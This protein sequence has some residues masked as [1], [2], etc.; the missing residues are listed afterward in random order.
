[1]SSRYALT[2]YDPPADLARHS[3]ALFHFASDA[4]EI[5]DRHPGALPQ[6]T[7]FPYGSGEMHFD[8]GTQVVSGEAHMLSGFS[9]AVPYTMTGPWHAIGI[10]L[11]H[12]GWAALTGE[13]VSQWIDRFI[14][15]RDILGADVMD[16]AQETNAAYRAGTLSGAQACQRLAEWIAPRFGVVPP[17]HETLIDQTI[18]WFG[19]SMN[20]DIDDLFPRLAYSR[21]QAERLVERYFGYPPAA[22][23]R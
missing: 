21:R 2:Y 7:L 19:G 17:S 3:L 14:D 15:P 22:L 9:K 10:S 18:A 13:P 5:S 6:L 8:T 23:A 11:S 4:A 16:F 12:L 20:P 1:M